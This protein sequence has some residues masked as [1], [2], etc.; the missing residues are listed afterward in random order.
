MYLPRIYRMLTNKKLQ[1]PV[2]FTPR[3]E[4]ITTEEETDTRNM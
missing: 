3:D 1:Q 4:A 2:N